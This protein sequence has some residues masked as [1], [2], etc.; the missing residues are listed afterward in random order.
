MIFVN[1]PVD[2]LA[3]SK[4]FYAALG[5]GVNEQFSDES[6]ACIVVS[7]QIFVMLLVRPRFADFVVG[8]VADGALVTEVINCLSAESRQEVDR[9]VGRALT[10]GGK[11]WKEKMDDGP[12]YGHSFADPDGHAWEVLH[13]DLP[14]KL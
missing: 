13:M 12:L 2:D 8:E 10:A 1:L 7:D 11:S 14:T 5:F 6:C 9:L 3:T 4:A